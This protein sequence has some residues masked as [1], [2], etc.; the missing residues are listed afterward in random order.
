[1]FKFSRKEV[2]TTFDNVKFARAAGALDNDGIEF[3]TK[4]VNIGGS[5]RRTGTLGDFGELSNLSI[6]Y[7]IYVDKKDFETAQYIISASFN[8]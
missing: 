6:Q 8:N 5:S 3:T 1:M 2:F 7:Y 4:A